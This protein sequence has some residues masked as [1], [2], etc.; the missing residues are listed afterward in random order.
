MAELNQHF[1][2]S[3]TALATYL[4]T[5]KFFLISVDYSKP[6]F[7]FIFTMSERIQESANTYLSGNALTD[8]VD[9]ARVFKKLNRIIYKRCQWEED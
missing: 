9:Y 8:P 1:K 3:D 6:R 2:T 7:E 4:I 5:D